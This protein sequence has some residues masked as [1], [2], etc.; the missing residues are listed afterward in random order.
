MDPPPDFPANEGLHSI[1][2]QPSSDS[3]FSPRVAPQHNYTS[4]PAG[5]I[6]AWIFSRTCIRGKSCSCDGNNLNIPPR[7]GIQDKALCTRLSPTIL[8]IWA[9]TGL[10]HHNELHPWWSLGS[11]ELLD[12]L[13]DGSWTGI[14]KVREK[15]VFLLII[16]LFINESHHA[17]MSSKLASI[18][19]WTN[20]VCSW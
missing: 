18:N 11:E 15:C 14:P 5:A 7:A 12:Y 9:E 3:A 6:F 20:Q 2:G 4:E 10:F 17:V 8:N 19:L 13:N 16:A 1:P